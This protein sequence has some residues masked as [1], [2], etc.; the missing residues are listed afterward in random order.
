MPQRIT[1]EEVLKR[2]K[3]AKLEKVEIDISTYISY[4]KK[5][6]FIDFEYGEWWTLPKYVIDN[7]CKHPQ[8]YNDEQRCGPKLTLK[9]VQILLDKIH[10]NLLFIISETYKGTQYKAKF[11]DSE[12]G[13]FDATVSHVLYS[14]SGHPKRGRD[15]SDITRRFTDK[16]INDILYEF[17]GG[18]IK[19]KNNTYVA[20]NKPATFIDIEYGE[21]TAI[22]ANVLKGNSHHPKRSKINKEKNIL[23]K[24]GCK[25]PMQNIE[26]FNKSQISRWK[27][28]K[29]KHWKTKE[30]LLCRGS[31]EFAVV[32]KL[33]ELKEDFK[34][35]IRFQLTEDIVYFCDLYLPDKNV[36]I[37]IKGFFWTERNKMKWEMFNLQHKNSELWMKKEVLTFSE[38]SD[39]M[40]RKQFREVLLNG[41]T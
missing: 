18:L 28:V 17:H 11:I 6:R 3:E 13:A 40:L 1:E 22:A 34:W 39:N 37:E 4:T 30:E 16:E 14:K 27:I 20:S 29:V 9:E 26:V 31:Y 38:K 7:K 25:N 5:C 8:R 23:E 2:F 41:D 33:N 35:Q 36:Y 15:K 12:Y 10:N 32:S 24:Y 21:W 19:L